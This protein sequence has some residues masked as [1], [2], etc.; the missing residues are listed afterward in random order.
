MRHASG[1]APSQTSFSGDFPHFASPPPEFSCDRMRHWATARRQNATPRHSCRTECRGIGHSPI[2][3]TSEW[4]NVA[5]GAFVALCAL[6]NGECRAEVR[7]FA[8]ALRLP[9]DRPRQNATLCDTIA[10]SHRR[11]PHFFG[12]FP[13]ST[14]PP[15]EISC[16][17]TRHGETERDV[18]RQNAT[19]CDRMQQ[20]ET[21]GRPPHCLLPSAYRLLLFNCQRPAPPDRAGEKSGCEARRARPARFFHGNHFTVKVNIKNLH[22]IK[23][24]EKVGRYD[25]ENRYNR[26]QLLTLGPK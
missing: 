8:S 16:D 19:A 13:Q 26:P 17:R 21:E 9:S 2:C 23:I 1:V 14:S 3:P 22:H 6:R 12:G 20:P 24:L 4:S 11:E 18:V 5:H 7:D 15:L 10:A 25:R